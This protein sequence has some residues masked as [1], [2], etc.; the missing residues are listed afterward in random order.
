[1]ITVT[2][3]LNASERIKVDKDLTDIAVVECYLLEP[4]SLIDPVFQFRG[5]LS[6]LANCNYFTVPAFKRS[7][8][9]VNPTSVANSYI[10]FSGH[11]DVISSWKAQ[12]R[13]NTGIIAKSESQWNLYLNDGSFKVYQNP[14]V[15]TRPF[16]NGFS[17]YEF[18][19]G[20]AGS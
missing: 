1:L 20:V 11:V 8:F 4:T 5:N 13:S 17:T 16:P 7:Y 10:Q 2:L 6:E 15:L 3:Q 14:L 12:I 19:L 9:L 18:V